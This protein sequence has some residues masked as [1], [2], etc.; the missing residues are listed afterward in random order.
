[1]AQLYRAFGTAFGVIAASHVTARRIG[2]TVPVGSGECIV[3]VGCVAAAVDHGAFFSQQCLL[4]QIGD[5]AVQFLDVVGDDRAFCI[6]PRAVADAVACVDRRY[7][8]CRLLA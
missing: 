7:A 5:R 8:I 4:G 1:M 2:A 6:G 3:C